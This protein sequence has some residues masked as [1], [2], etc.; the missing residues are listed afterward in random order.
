MS[1]PVNHMLKGYPKT[2]SQ[3]RDFI[4]KLGFMVIPNFAT[5]RLQFLGI[6]KATSYLP[7]G[8]GCLKV[9]TLSGKSFYVI[10]CNGLPDIERPLSPLLQ[11]DMHDPI[12]SQRWLK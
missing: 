10:Y 7:E 8:D 3:W 2:P 4:N 1:F 9:E 11:V 5:G 6:Q 12:G